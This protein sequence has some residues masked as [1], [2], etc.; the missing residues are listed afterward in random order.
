MSFIK[1][2][3]GVLAGATNAY[4]ALMD[5]SYIS[6]TDSVA[7]I[8]AANYFL[9]LCL[10]KENPDIAV[11]QKIWIKAQDG[12][13]F[14]FFNTITQSSVTVSLIFDTTVF[15]RKIVTAGL[16]TSVAG[17]TAQ[18][19]TLNGVIDSDIVLV[20]LRS[21]GAFAGTILRAVSLNGEVAIHYSSDPGNDTVI[22]Y[23]VIR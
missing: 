7:T 2:N 4:G 11:G 13:V 1:K 22:N 18:T 16:Y 12:Y 5:W 8:I 20:T 19:I 3:F 6:D 17:L 10:D 9:E 14:V 21:V 15:T 23:T